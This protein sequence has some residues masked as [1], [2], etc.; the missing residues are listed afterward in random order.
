MVLAVQGESY[1]A[2]ARRTGVSER[3]VGRIARETGRALQ[4]NERDY[5][6]LVYNAFQDQ[7]AA[8]SAQAQLAGDR[9][10]LL[11]FPKERFPKLMEST[12]N[13]AFRFLTVLDFSDD[14][15]DPSH[16]Q[17]RGN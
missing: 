7:R 1:A 13:Q 9:N 17:E 5:R 14:D 11:D 6:D 4:Q 3:S 15:A 16:A 2:I 12:A 10:W 8:L